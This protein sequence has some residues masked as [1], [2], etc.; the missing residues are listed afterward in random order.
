M[1]LNTEKYQTAGLKQGN[2]TIIVAS[3]GVVLVSMM[4]LHP[5]R[6]PVSR[7]ASRPA[8][9]NGLT[10]S[11]NQSVAVHRTTPEESFDELAMEIIERQVDLPYAVTVLLA[12]NLSKYLD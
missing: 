9:F 10:S 11:S 12:N 2:S 5:A 6:E 1:S 7:E 3:C 8:Y 4:A